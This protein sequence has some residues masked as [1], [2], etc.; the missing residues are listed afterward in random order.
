[1]WNTLFQTTLLSHRTALAPSGR[2]APKCPRCADGNS[3]R[4]VPQVRH[5]PECQKLYSYTKTE[6]IYPLDQRSCVANMLHGHPP[7]R[8]KEPATQTCRHQKEWESKGCAGL[9]HQ[10]Y[11]FIQG[12]GGGDASI[13]NYFYPTD[14]TFLIPLNSDTYWLAS[15]TH[16]S[17][18]GFSPHPSTIKH[19]NKQPI[20]PVT[21]IIKLR[22]FYILEDL[23]GCKFENNTGKEGRRERKTSLLT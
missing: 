14:L 3:W 2:S 23:S 5:T 4:W 8:H 19:T 18:F 1:M 17:S 13:P 20:S 22:V 9:R 11:G 6:L 12:W 21:V 15:I 16:I 7:S 10:R